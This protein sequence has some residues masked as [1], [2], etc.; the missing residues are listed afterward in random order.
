MKREGKNGVGVNPLLEVV[1]SQMKTP[2]LLA[3]EERDS[4]ELNAD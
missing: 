4:T 3:Q 1:L 2:L